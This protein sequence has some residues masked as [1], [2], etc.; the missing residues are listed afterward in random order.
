MGQC[1]ISREWKTSQVFLT[2]E[3]C[4][5]LKDYFN[6]KVLPQGYEIDIN[7]LFSKFDDVKFK[8]NMKWIFGDVFKDEDAD[9][10]SSFV[11]QTKYELEI[12]VTYTDERINIEYW[13]FD[14]K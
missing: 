11:L 10:T 4:E 5:M 3:D 6:G 1:N 12:N 8:K 14:Y 13:A 2:D 7:E 9:Y